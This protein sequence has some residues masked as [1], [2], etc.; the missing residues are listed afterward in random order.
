MKQNRTYLPQD[1]KYPFKG[2]NTLAPP[3]MLEPKYSPYCMNVI[4]DKGIL[5]KRNGSIQLGDVFGERVIALPTYESEEGTLTT[6]AIT[7]KHQYRCVSGVWEEC[8]T[9]ELDDGSDVGTWNPVSANVTLTNVASALHVAVGD[10]VGVG[11]I[12]WTDDFDPVK[13]LTLSNKT[14]LEIKSSINIAAGKL[15]LVVSEETDG[16]RVTNY[17]DC[18]IPELTADTWTKVYIAATNLAFSDMN[19]VLS[20]GF[21]QDVDLGAFTFDVKDIRVVYEWSGDED[22]WVDSVEGTDNNGK[23][24]FLTNGKDRLIYWNGSVIVVFVPNSGLD[25]FVTCRAVAIYYGSLVLGNITTLEDY[26]SSAAYS[27]PGDFFDFSSIGSDLVLLEGTRG[28]IQRILPLSQ[29]LVIYGTSSMGLCRLIEGIS[30][31]FFDQIFSGESRILN[32]R[33]VINLGAYHAVMM[34]DGIY[35]FDGTKVLRPLSK[36]IQRTYIKLLDTDYAERAVAFNDTFTKKA[37]FVI[38][39]SQDAVEVFYLDYQDPS[40]EELIWARLDFTDDPICFGFYSQQDAYTWNSAI[41]QNPWESVTATWD[42]LMGKPGFPFIVMGTDTKVLMESDVGFNDGLVKVGA[43]WESTEV[44]AEWQSIDFVVPQ[45][46]LSMQGRWTEIELELAGKDVS[47][48][49]SLDRGV[50]WTLIEDMDLTPANKRYNLFLDV[51][52]PTL[53]I[54]LSTS[55][56]FSLYWY[57]VWLTIGGI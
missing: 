38:P 34:Q 31:Y 16:G 6:F 9:H 53:R 4:S 44:E 42:E 45:H 1:S 27:L 52:S 21:Y 32:G 8:Y 40:L 15:V 3:T 28:G 35:L 55:S 5:R 14:V 26:P 23:Y 7:A 37:Y 49:Y 11:I 47:V 13:D 51:V 30:Q 54:K 57:R 56:H 33:A 46:Y 41:A 50:N 17:I 36:E 24:L 2:L 29:V 48:S 22:D 20:I 43:D 25:G 19:A 18:D 39:R 12:C 10:A